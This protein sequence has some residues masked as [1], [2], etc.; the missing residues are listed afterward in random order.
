MWYWHKDRHID[1]WKGIE[2]SE[3]NSHM[4]GQMIFD[5]AVPR[6]LSGKGQSFQLI[7]WGK[8]DI[9]IPKDE[10]RPLPIPYMDQGPK[11]K[12]QNNTTLRRKQDKSFITLDIGFSDM[13]SNSQITKEKTNSTSWKF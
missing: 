10:V 11:C 5:K 12:T 3:I 6:E 9:H 7:V 1:Q 8:L 4:Y 2:S 13:T